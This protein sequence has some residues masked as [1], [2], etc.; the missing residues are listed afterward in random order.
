VCASCARPL[1][2]L[3]DD[4]VSDHDELY[5]VPYRVVYDINAL[6]LRR[7]DVVV[8]TSN[9]EGALRSV[10]I[11]DVT[12]NI[13]VNPDQPD[14]LVFIPPD[15]DYQLQSSGRKIIAISYDGLSV[16]YSIEVK[17]PLGAEEGDDG[18]GSGLTVEWLLP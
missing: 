11:T 3:Y 18:G 7:S 13:A 10:P 6:F 2:S 15:E 12:I 14:D 4:T 1:G 8:F 17:N 16:R 9:K 5:A